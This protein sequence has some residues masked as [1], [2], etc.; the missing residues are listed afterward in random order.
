M[1]VVILPYPS[2]QSHPRPPMLYR[3]L[4]AS[5]VAA[6]TPWTIAARR[7]ILQRRGGHARRDRH[8]PNARRDTA[9]TPQIDFLV[10]P[11]PFLIIVHPPFYV[12][13][14]PAPLLPA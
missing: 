10:S 1:P 4:L 3:I 5:P 11:F 13:L 7:T 14:D 12:I 2:Y 8:S 9:Q 6:S